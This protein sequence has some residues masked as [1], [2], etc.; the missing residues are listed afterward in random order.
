MAVGSLTLGIPA[1]GGAD[2]RGFTIVVSASNSLDPTLAPAVYRCD[3]VSDEATINAA[4][5]ALP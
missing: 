3:G 2:T 5:V 4:I 1:G